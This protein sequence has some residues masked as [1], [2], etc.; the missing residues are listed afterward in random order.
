[1]YELTSQF[2]CKIKLCHSF[3]LYLLKPHNPSVHKGFD[4]SLVNKLPIVGPTRNCI[5]IIHSR[6]RPKVT[7]LVVFAYIPQ[8]YFFIRFR[9]YWV[10]SELGILDSR[11]KSQHPWHSYRDS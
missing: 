1:M 11:N 8:V 10:I 6:G 4:S 2:E 5:A 3:D 7:M 9:E